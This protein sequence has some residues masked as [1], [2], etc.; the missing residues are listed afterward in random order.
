MITLKNAAE[1]RKFRQGLRGS[2]GF[3]PTMGAL[4]DGHLSLVNRS[5]AENAHTIISIYVNPTQFNN[6]SDL[7]S[8]PDTLQEDVRQLAAAGASALF[9]PDY[10]VLY[11]D[12]FRYEVVEKVFSEDLCG[13]HRP[14]HF[15]GVMTVV[16]K[17]LNLVNAQKAYFGEKDFQQLVLIR[18]MT[19]A[20][21]IDTE[22]VGC[23]IV[24]ERDGL[25]MSSRN[26]NLSQA[27]RRK[28]PCFGRILRSAKN[29]D[30]AVR[31]LEA[32]GFDIDY[33]ETRQGRRFG[34]V[35]MGTEASPVR[36]IDNV[37]L[38]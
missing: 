3:V 14:G 11:P 17:L 26:Q 33:V 30:E 31:Q 35:L 37:S 32:A 16:M 21:F 19:E 12:D 24:R 18:G 22:I 28:S 10:G 13:A 5:I 27:D 2:V 4:H 34:A 9:L 1:L 36:L 6:P 29:D 23:P 38:G 8:Y 15:T 7:A 25:A 20:F